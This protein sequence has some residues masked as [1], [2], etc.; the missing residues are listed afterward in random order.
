[1]KLCFILHGRYGIAEGFIAEK[2]G[3]RT[4]CVAFSRI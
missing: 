4:I 2:Q 3:G 1:M